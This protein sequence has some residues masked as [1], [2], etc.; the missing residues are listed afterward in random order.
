MTKPLKELQQAVSDMDI[1]IL[2]FKKIKRLKNKSLNEYEDYY[3][4]IL[5]SLCGEQIWQI[6]D[7]YEAVCFIKNERKNKHAKN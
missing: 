4:K 6:L 7:A 5:T 3:E 1:K 2:P